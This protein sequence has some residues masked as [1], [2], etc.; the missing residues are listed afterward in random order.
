[1]GTLLRVTTGVSKEISTQQLFYTLVH[2]QATA[3]IVTQVAC[4]KCA[5]KQRVEFQN[6]Y[7]R[8]TGDRYHYKI[9]QSLHF[10]LPLYLYLLISVRGK[11]GKILINQDL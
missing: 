10:A 8:H 9:F 7:E 5:L 3:R 11:S 4:L 2:I 6:N 1:M